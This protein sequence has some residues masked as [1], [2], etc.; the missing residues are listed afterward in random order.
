MGL[1]DGSVRD[2]FAL[3]WRGKGLLLSR[4]R[5]GFALSLFYLLQ[6]FLLLALTLFEL[7]IGLGH[8]ACFLGNI[9]SH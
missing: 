7:V 8:L 2:R 6:L 1:A 3:P 5:I 9:C 4:H